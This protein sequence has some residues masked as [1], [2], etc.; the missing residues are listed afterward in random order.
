MGRGLSY[1]HFVGQSPVFVNRFAEPFLHFV[2]GI[3]GLYDSESS[4]SLLHLRHRVTPFCLGLQRVPFQAFSQCTHTPG[5]CRH[6][7]DGEK[8]E[9]PACK[10]QGPEIESDENR[11]LEQHIQRTGDG[12][13]HLAHVSADSG[14]DVTLAL[15]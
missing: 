2:L 9:L 6:H 11:V 14:N 13:F 7:R 8:C 1:S 5:H 10:E 15:L 12:I 4:K 3:E